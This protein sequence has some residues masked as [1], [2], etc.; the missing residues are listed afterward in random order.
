MFL[1]TRKLPYLLLPLALLGSTIGLKAF[2]FDGYSDIIWHNETTGDVAAWFL[3]L[4]KFTTAAIITDDLPEGWRVAATADFNRDG[5]LDLFLNSESTAENEIWLMSLVDR[6]ERIPVITGSPAFKIAGT[7]D[8]NGDGF[9]DILWR[10]PAR[11]SNVAW[12][13]DGT[14]FSGSVGWLTTRSQFSWNIAAT[15]DF[16]NDG[17]PDIVWRDRFDGSNTVWLMN[18]LDLLQSVEIK[19]QPDLSSQ[20]AG[21]GSFNLLGNTDLIWRHSNGDNTIWLMK[22]TDYVSTAELPTVTRAD[23]RIGAAGGYTNE[24]LLTAVSEEP[25]QGLNVRWKYGPHLKPNI[26]RKEY[27]A[28]SWDLL[29]TNY[30][31]RRFTD[32]NIAIGQRYEYKIGNDYLLTGIAAAPIEDRGKIILV[33][34]DSISLG[35]QPFVEL[36]KSDLVGDGWSVILTNAPRHIDHDWPRNIQPIALLKNFITNVYYADPVRTKAVYLLGHVPIPYSGFSNPD[37]HGARALPADAYYGDVDGIYTDE[38][39]HSF[40]RLPGAREP[41][42]D[43]FIGDGRL[44]QPKIPPNAEGIAEIELAVGRVDFAS[45]GAFF[46]KSEHDLT[47]Q[48]I[49]K[50]H[51]YRH[52]EFTLPNRVSV[53]TFFGTGPN[54]DAYGQALRMSSRLFGSDPKHLVKGDP[55]D[56]NNPALWG[57]MA[58]SGLPWGLAYD[59]F[60]YHQALDLGK[61]N[62]EPRLAFANFFGSFF[63]DFHYQDNFM[64]SFLATPRF[65]LA[66]MWFKPV[67]IDRIGL[68]F[69]PVG[70]GETIG[71]GFVRTIN[72]SQAGTKQNMFLALLGDPTLRLQVQAP[73]SA[74]PTFTQSGFTDDFV[75]TLSMEWAPSTETDATYLVHRSRNGFEG[76]WERLTPEPISETSFTDLSALGPPV[77]YQVRTIGLEKTGSGSYYNLSQGVF[78]EAQ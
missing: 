39:V 62:R 72:E 50:T 2:D 63:V 65:G 16:N 67:S 59:A 31:P 22:G 9:E 32:T 7:G 69:E 26:Q 61:T 12:F 8:F 53:E 30:I 45:L 21:T 46:P 55:F 10:D 19:A 17:N 73:P 33:V 4:T 42:H 15:G 41:R 20:L 29:A 5:Q 77:M 66:A 71:T 38:I 23:W 14:A 57:I 37:G 60:T 6:I 1:G 75:W 36:L 51:R 68:G 74:P 64:R 76:P 70:L 34:E 58:G 13:M 43:N 11:N 52:K 48:Y 24:M 44:D 28:T 40:S 54:R 47:Q 3:D 18:G 27:G 78:V 35:S 56:T 49:L 25:V